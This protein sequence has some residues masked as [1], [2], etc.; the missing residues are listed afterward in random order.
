[1]DDEGKS[2]LVGAE[3]KEGKYIKII[4]EPE[5]EEY[6]EAAE[7]CPVEAVHIINKETGEKII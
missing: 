6:R 7:S 5:L 2:E 4:D 3:K 1:M